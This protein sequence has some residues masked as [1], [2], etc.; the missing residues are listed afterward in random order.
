MDFQS[1]TFYRGGSLQSTDIIVMIIKIATRIMKSTNIGKTTKVTD[2][3]VNQLGGQRL[4]VVW[5][6]FPHFVFIDK[7]GKIYSY[8][9][10]S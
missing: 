3:F 10:S 7:C 6:D 1:P 4:T 8:N 9:M 5:G 2:C